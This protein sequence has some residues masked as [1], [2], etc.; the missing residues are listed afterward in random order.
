VD[1]VWLYCIGDSNGKDDSEGVWML[2]ES[3]LRRI[4]CYVNGKWKYVKSIGQLEPGDTF[5]VFEPDGTPIKNKHGNCSFIAKGDA[6][7][8]A[9]SLP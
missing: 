5:R 8:E 4:E 3:E 1:Q 9:E 6:G 7:I 2:A